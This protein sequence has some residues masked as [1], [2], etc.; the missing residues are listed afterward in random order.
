[1]GNGLAKLQYPF[2]VVLAGDVQYHVIADVVLLLPFVVQHYVSDQF[3]SAYLEC[4]IA[5]KVV[6]SA[7]FARGYYIYLFTSGSDEPALGE[8]PVLPD[9]V[10]RAFHGICVFCKEITQTPPKSSVWRG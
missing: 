7:L 5:E 6:L 1:M 8:Q 3:F 9:V 4:C 10:H 2:T